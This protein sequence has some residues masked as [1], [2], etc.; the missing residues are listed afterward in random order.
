VLPLLKVLVE[1]VNF[2]LSA[3]GVPAQLP[4]AAKEEVAPAQLPAEQVG[5]SVAIGELVDGVIKLRVEGVTPEI[6][7]VTG[8]PPPATHVI[9]SA[10]TVVPFCGDG[11]RRRPNIAPSGAAARRKIDDL[12]R[13]DLDRLLAID[14]LGAGATEAKTLERQCAAGDLNRK[15][16]P[17]GQASCRGIRQGRGASAPASGQLDNRGGVGRTECRRIRGSAAKRNGRADLVSGACAV[18]P[19]GNVGRS[20]RNLI[21]AQ[22]G[23][24]EAGDGPHHTKAGGKKLFHGMLNHWVAVDA[25]K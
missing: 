23:L 19:P 22:R 4:V 7:G 2:P 21:R 17:A 15:T 14:G 1:I 18:W 8:P 10:S 6:T 24:R 5:V 3:L 13:P 20:R 16:A 25:S 12:I 11:G 9:L